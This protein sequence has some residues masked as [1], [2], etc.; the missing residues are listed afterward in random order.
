MCTIWSV[1]RRTAS[2]LI[3]LT[4]TGTTKCQVPTKCHVEVF[5]TF[6]FW[7]PYSLN[8]ITTEVLSTLCWYSVY[9][10]LSQ[11]NFEIRLIFQSKF[12]KK[13]KNYFEWPQKLSEKFKSR[14]KH[15]FC[16]G[17]LPSSHFSNH[18][19]AKY[20]YRRI[21]NIWK[22][23]VWRERGLLFCYASSVHISKGVLDYL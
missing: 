6:P 5:I 13:A 22:R 15:I 9:I 17:I 23:D 18:I 11:N 3:K 1:Q 7:Y 21:A 19:S 14:Q 2:T 16:K 12:R 8:L 4:G 20:W 10:L